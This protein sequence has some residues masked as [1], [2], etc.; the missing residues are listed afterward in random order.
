MGVGQNVMLKSSGSKF[1]VA[2]SESSWYPGLRRQRGARFGFGEPDIR[3]VDV[4]ADSD[5]QS[6]IS[7]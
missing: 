1:G 4:A 5:I 2:T 6:E 7:A 3:G